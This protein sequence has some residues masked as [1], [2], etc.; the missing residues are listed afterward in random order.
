MNQRLT[1]VGACIVR[2]TRHAGDH[3][4]QVSA[5][6]AEE[7][8]TIRECVPGTFNVRMASSPTYEPPDDARYRC[9]A[10][11]RGRSVG[12]Y[13]DGNHISPRA[14]VVAINGTQ[15]EAWLYRGGNAPAILELVSRHWLA[16]ALRVKDGAKVT[17]EI[18]ELPEGAAGMPAPPPSRPG[19]TVGTA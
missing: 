19:G 5:D 6:H 11:M 14:R 4:E 7:F 8:P 1:I 3:W 18:E 12:R 17:V 9:Q 10:R 15:L 2:G 16:E 13:Q